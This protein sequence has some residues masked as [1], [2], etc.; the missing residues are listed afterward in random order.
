MRRTVLPV[1]LERER[2]FSERVSSV[3]GGSRTGAGRSRSVTLRPLRCGLCGRSKGRTVR[4]R[5]DRAGAGCVR[6]RVDC[7]VRYSTA[8][9]APCGRYVYRV[10][11]VSVNSERTVTSVGTLLWCM[12][13]APP[14]L[15]KALGPS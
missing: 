2:D 5:V 4:G 13:L 12:S 10:A 7:A 8:P 11:T 15:R 14:A 9:A 1:P 3:W 6:G